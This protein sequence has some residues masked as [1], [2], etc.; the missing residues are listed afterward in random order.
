MQSRRRSA[1]DRFLRERKVA[2]KKKVV[3]Q[4]SVGNFA[5]EVVAV[6][7]LLVVVGE[8]YFCSRDW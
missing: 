5:F 1:K 6:R 4:V 3:L 2:R 7:R 8:Q